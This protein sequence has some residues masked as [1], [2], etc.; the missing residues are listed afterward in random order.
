MKSDL[1]TLQLLAR[2]PGEV[3]Q[4]AREQIHLINAMVHTTGGQ[5]ALQE[6]LGIPLPLRLSDIV[7]LP[8]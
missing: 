5:L 7:S 2:M 1:E 6:V 4:L 8:Y 3:G